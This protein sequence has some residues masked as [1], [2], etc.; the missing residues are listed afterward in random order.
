MHVL[1]TFTTHLFSRR[2]SSAAAHTA[3]AAH[4]P[5][6]PQTIIR[7]RR[8][9]TAA[10]HH[11]TTYT[12]PRFKSIFLNTKK[13]MKFEI[14]IYWAFYL[15][16]ECHFIFHFM[17]LKLIFICNK[18]TISWWICD[19]DFTFNLQRMSVCCEREKVKSVTFLAL[20]R[21]IY[22]ILD[23][24]FCLF[25]RAIISLLGQDIVLWDTD[26]LTQFNKLATQN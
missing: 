9:S 20:K 24:T 13:Q 7:R 11:Y 5:P 2:T 16:R 6:P 10:A 4:H 17:L 25:Y 1:L 19:C 23:S 14:G 18:F 3:A 21:T 15:V 22:S 26:S 8:P 12:C